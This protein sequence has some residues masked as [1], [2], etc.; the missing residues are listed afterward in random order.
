MKKLKFGLLALLFTVGVGGAMVQKIHAAP[1]LVDT[2][3]DWTSTD[4][5]PSNP[6]SELP[7]ATIAQ[8][9]DNFGCASG[10]TDCADGQKVSGPGANTAQIQHN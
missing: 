2:F 1:K 3:Y 5:A 7:D 9:E 6:S 10:L 4:T 8:A